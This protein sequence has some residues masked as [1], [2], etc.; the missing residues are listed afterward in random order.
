M[1]M[2]GGYYD[3]HLGCERA[4]RHHLPDAGSEVPALNPGQ[5]YS[6]GFNEQDLCEQDE[7]VMRAPGDDD[8]EDARFQEEVQAILDES[9]APRAGSGG[10]GDDGDDNEP[11]VPGPGENM[12]EPEEEPDAALLA[13]LGELTVESFLRATPEGGEAVPEPETLISDAV[14]L[15]ESAADD[16]ERLTAYRAIIDEGVAGVT[17]KAIAVLLNFGEVYEDMSDWNDMAQEEQAEL[18]ATTLATT[19]QFEAAER[20]VTFLGERNPSTAVNTIAQLL[21]KGFAGRDRRFLDPADPLIAAGIAE[22]NPTSTHVTAKYLA[23]LAES[24]ENVLDVTTKAGSLFAAASGRW[25]E[26]ESKAYYADIAMAYARSGNIA[27]ALL[28]NNAYQPDETG[29]QLVR[30]DIASEAISNGNEDVARELLQ[31]GLSLREVTGAYDIAPDAYDIRR[32]RVCAKLGNFDTATKLCGEPDSVLVYDQ[33]AVHGLV[34]EESDDPAERQQ[35]RAAVMGCI[36]SVGGAKASTRAADIIESI[37]RN[38]V[39]HGD[40]VMS[41]EGELVPRIYQETDGL[42]ASK[43]STLSQSV[44]EMLAREGFDSQGYEMFLEGKLRQIRD[45][46]QC[47]IAGVLTE[48]GALQTAKKAISSIH[49]REEKARAMVRMAQ[50]LRGIT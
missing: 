31:S 2:P 21:R 12:G 44:L 36:R 42:L 34:Y 38:D 45:V 41:A 3:Y 46:A 14:E 37:A 17:D 25:T 47:K 49:S 27:K 8:S 43:H 50:R 10:G 40:M 18:L 4:T 32:A 15:V 26:D 16:H 48:C 5:T 30:M 33:A 29:K 11:P 6:G 9:D 22:E 13:G 20:V 39:K 7:V 23:G 35:A 28:I 1:D 24:G 19:G